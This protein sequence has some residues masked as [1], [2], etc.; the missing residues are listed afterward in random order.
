MEAWQAVHDMGSCGEK[1][2]RQRLAIFVDS[3]QSHLNASDSPAD[4]RKVW[5]ETRELFR[6]VMTQQPSVSQT[7]KL[8]LEPLPRYHRDAARTDGERRPALS[9]LDVAEFDKRWSHVRDDQLWAEAF[10]MDRMTSLWQLRHGRRSERQW[11]RCRWWWLAYPRSGWYLWLDFWYPKSSRSPVDFHPHW[12]LPMVK[13]PH[14]PSLQDDLSV[15]LQPVLWA[16]ASLCPNSL[17][18]SRPSRCSLRRHQCSIRQHLPS[19]ESTSSLHKPSTGRPKRWDKVHWK[20]NRES[21]LKIKREKSFS[22]PGH[23]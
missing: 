12:C 15:P 13:L 17:P 3:G 20:G 11:D 19:M 9:R 8:C 21:S 18:H 7:R 1:N 10:P 4:H 2:L 6:A 23:G 14:Q 16:H 22:Y 5:W